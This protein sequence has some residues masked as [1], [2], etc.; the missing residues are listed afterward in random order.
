MAESGKSYLIVGGSS[1]IGREIV[2]QVESEGGVV[3]LASRNP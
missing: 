2:R 1:G 3:Y